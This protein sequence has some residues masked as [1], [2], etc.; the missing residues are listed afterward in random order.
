LARNRT[1]QLIQELNNLP[2]LSEVATQALKLATEDT[3]TIDK[4]ASLVESDPAMSVKLLRLVN[5]A[6]RGLE[7][8]V[9]N[10]K[11]A[12]V[13]LGLEA[14]KSAI[15]SIQVLEI[16]D[17][18]QSKNA[19][20]EL[21]THLFGVGTLCHL[22]AERTKVVDPEI[23]FVCGLLHDMGK[24]ALAAVS[25]QSYR[26]AVEKCEENE[27]P[28]LEA[29]KR[30]FGLTH[31][32][33]GKLL[34]EKWNLSTQLTEVI[35]LHHQPLEIMALEGTT[36]LLRIV[37]AADTQC[38]KQG[39]G[40][41][42]NWQ[43]F[44]DPLELLKPLG[45]TA[46]NMAEISAV[47]GHRLEEHANRF[48]LEM[49]DGEVYLKALQG[50]NNKLGRLY[51]KLDE[52]KVFNEVKAKE[53]ETLH[54][55]NLA[56]GASH[57][58]EEAIEFIGRYAIEMFWVKRVVVY[59]FSPAQQL[60]AGKVVNSDGS[61]DDLHVICGDDGGKEDKG[62]EN[63]R[64]LFKE[65]IE[66]FLDNGA[67]AEMSGKTGATGYVGDL[68]ALPL[69]LKGDLHAGIIVDNR[70][71]PD[72]NHSKKTTL[73]EWLAFTDAAALSLERERL[74]EQVTKD[75]EKLLELQ[76]RAR[77][78]EDEILQSKKMA[79]LG[80]VA[81]G[82]AHEMNNPLTI[83]SGR[84]QILFSKEQDDQQKKM[85]QV[86]IGQCER[87]SKIITDLLSYS[88][89]HPPARERFDLKEALKQVID[90][91]G[92]TLQQKKIKV[93]TRFGEGPIHAVAD[94]MQIQ[95][96]VT[97]LVVNAIH[98][99][100]PEGQLTLSASLDPQRTEIR[101]EVSDSGEGI[102]AAD[103]EHIFEP[104]FSTKEVG[105]GTGLGLSISHSIVTAHGGRILVR[106]APGKGSTFT[107]LLPAQKGN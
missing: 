43:F 16:M 25:H 66:R 1:R 98:A 71:Q 24:I 85:L 72:E 56:L 107:V 61:I 44:D 4:L 30:L 23:A 42:G 103:L 53:F 63:N 75:V 82:A 65:L 17:A 46:S 38:R 94:R 15:L 91:N 28:L 77:Q 29:E 81:A 73:A 104:F 96:V 8:P 100:E 89:P 69:E 6:W 102:P 59:T 57:S 20:R 58:I 93:E 86:I 106:S 10:V 70:R 2:T 101:I 35:W 55:M 105:R 13:L 40:F 48:G 45:L 14:V 7:K 36:D 22:L 87:L 31:L 52:L 18:A 21:W 99:M 78:M 26:G 83:I 32:E 51:E 50:A 54:Q 9:T 84:A 19:D 11:R 97:N 80:R 92:P 90:L 67:R 12:I 60:L 79:A 95:Q 5:S 64:R 74:H 68:F 3:A 27:E 33:A 41:S 47:F 88:R 39:V 76:R 34:S 62:S 37:V 49:E